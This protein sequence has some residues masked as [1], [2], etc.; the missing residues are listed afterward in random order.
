MTNESFESMLQDAFA[1]YAAQ[2][3]EVLFVQLGDTHVFSR[4]FRKNMKR[5][6]RKYHMGTSVLQSEY[7]CRRRWLSGLI[8]LLIALVAGACTL[9]EV[10]AEIIEPCIQWFRTHVTFSYTEH[11][12]TE[13]M[14]FDSGL[15]PGYL[16]EGYTL[17]NSVEGEEFVHLEYSDGKDQLYV[18]Y[19][20]HEEIMLDIEHRHAHTE[21]I[22]SFQGCFWMQV[23]SEHENALQWEDAQYVFVIIGNLNE[24]ELVK[25]AESLYH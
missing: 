20:L 10:Q 16:P 12:S 2:Q 22:G 14:G 6:L 15:R 21:S 25:I 18:N 23:D 1:E 19:G 9:P 7:T 13:S 3:D 5:M 8:V 4:R 11:A 17:Y 24:Q